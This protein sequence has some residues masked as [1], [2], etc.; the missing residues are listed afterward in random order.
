MT[1]LAGSALRQLCRHP[2]HGTKLVVLTRL[3]M[4]KRVRPHRADL[5]DGGRSLRDPVTIVHGAYTIIVGQ[6]VMVYLAHPAT[7][8]EQ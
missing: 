5:I 3:R 1:A 4:T 6:R 8:I 7:Q 2:K